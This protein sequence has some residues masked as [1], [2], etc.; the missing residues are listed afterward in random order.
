MVADKYMYV[1]TKDDHRPQKRRFYLSCK[2]NFKEEN[3]EKES[4]QYQK[5]ISYSLL[6]IFFILATHLGTH[7]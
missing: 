6:Q 2:G 4:V 5:P 7:N 1:Y 3:S